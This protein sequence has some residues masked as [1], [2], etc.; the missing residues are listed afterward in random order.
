MLE[1]VA[2]TGKKELVIICEDLDGEALATLILNKL[3]GIFNILAVKAP[4]FGDR[5]KEMLKDIAIVTG[6]TVISEEIGMKLETANLEDLG[7]ARKVVA[8]KDKTTIVQ[9]KGNKAE[10]ESR[11]AELKVMIDKSNSEFDKEKLAERLAKLAGGVGVIKVGAATEV[12]LK[13][14]KLRIEDA[15]SATKAAIAEGIIPGG[16][17]ALAQIAKKLI[18]QVSGDDDESTGMHILFSALSIPLGQIAINA[19]ESHEVVW[20]KVINAKK[21]FGI[22]FSKPTKRGRMKSQDMELVDYGKRGDYRSCDG[23]SCCCSECRFSGRNILN[24]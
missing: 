7:Q 17:V 10:I 5:R 2:T 3:R 9:G 4:A 12:E 13:E 22:D 15:V 14:R 20:D 18:E 8:D 11:V 16:G 1:K 6:G 24:N 21:G 19:G 23:G